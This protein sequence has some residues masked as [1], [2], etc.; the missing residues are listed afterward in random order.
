MNGGMSFEELLD[1]ELAD[2]NGLLAD[3]KPAK[4]KQKAASQVEQQ[5]QEIEDFFERNKRLPELSSSDVLEHQLA[6][7]LKAYQAR[8]DLKAAVKHLDRF[9]LLDPKEAVAKQTLSDDGKAP[10][11]FD[12]ILF[13]NEG[14]LPD[15][16]DL[17]ILN[18]EHVK[19][20]TAEDRNWSEE[21]ASRKQCEDFFKFEKLF[22]DTQAD[23]VNGK[24]RTERFKGETQIEVGDFFIVEGLLCLVDSILEYDKDETGKDNPRLRVIF[25]NGVESNLL[26]LSLAR[27]LYRDPHGRRIIPPPETVE[28]RFQGLTHHDK[29]TGCVY[30]LA[31]ETKAP[32]L[33]DLKRQGRLVKI[34][35]STQSVEERT[36]HAAEDPTYLEAPVRI[37]ASIDCYNLN[38]QKVEHLIHAFLW[39]QR[40][41][42]TLISS[43][44]VKY[45]PSEWFAVDRDTAIAVAQHIVKGDITEYRMDNT[46]GRIKKCS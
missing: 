9:G 39:N 13:D 46:T 3:V 18:L 11:S 12:E 36:R 14:S 37:L 20:H 42:M 5:F 19:P 45:K 21:I 15:G 28:K 27:A 30:V 10:N 1:E 34:G 8:K 17:S 22:K 38:P 29:A 6:A 24:L 40:I 25:D 31:S 16:V 23:I 35:Y 44:G 4:P 7:R 2:P 43:K 33:A 26:K 41:N 32:E